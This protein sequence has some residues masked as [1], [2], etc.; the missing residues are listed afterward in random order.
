MIIEQN[1]YAGMQITDHQTSVPLNWN[2]AANSPHIDLFC[3]EVCASGRQ[4]EQL[5]LLVYLQGGP[6]GKSPRPTAAGPLWLH[7]AIKRFRVI[8]PDQRGTGRSSRISDATMATFDT[9]E[10]AA[11]YLACF[12][13]HAIIADCEHI[14]TTVYQGAPWSTLGQS[15]GGFL[16][17]TYLSYAPHGLVKSYITGGLPALAP[18]ADAVY[19]RTY[20]RVAE[21]MAAHWRRFPA[22]KE[23]LNAIA[24]FIETYKPTLPNG[25][26]LTVRRLQTLGLMLGM[27]DGSERLH[28]LLE[29][30]F[31][32]SSRQALNAHFLVAVM[33]ATGLD[34]NPLFAV[35]H[36]NIYANP[37]QS[38]NWAAQRQ[39]PELF[40]E[41]HR[42]L[43]L[44]G[45]MIFAWMFDEISALR[46]YRDA[47]HCLASRRAT[48]P[49]YDADQLA[50]NTV[51]VAAAIYYDDM[52]VDT[53]LSQPTATAIN[54]LNYWITNEYEHDGL[55][56]DS[57]VFTYLFDHVVNT[58]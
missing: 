52:F 30:A 10:Q 20:Q 43:Y 16:T 48:K 14:R 31:T 27:G 51:P 24:D 9:A 22:D 12:D 56:Q 36:E 13:A 18:D 1:N 7:E 28:W 32:D 45:E 29:E 34:D 5:P 44:T 58:V 41:S 25:D 2:D 39:R 15:Y 42:P 40:A 53:R 35:L 17:L 3:R 55:R 57:R 47:V 38:C 50:R 23:R 54:N 11:D 49:Y 8:L 19:E 46:P 33:T 21:K 4:D 37:H 26:P 6:G